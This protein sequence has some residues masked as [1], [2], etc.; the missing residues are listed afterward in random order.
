[1]SEA[2]PIHDE[3]WSLLNAACDDS[4][5]ETQARELA[6]LLDADDTARRA[7][8]E[9]VQLRTD[10]R[11][12]HLAHKACDNGLAQIQATFSEPSPPA[13]LPIAT[14]H[15]TPGNTFQAWSL[16][17]L[18]TAVLFGVAVWIGA[19]V[20]VSHL[21]KGSPASPSHI[22]GTRVDVGRITALADCQWSKQGSGISKTKDLRPK[23]VF[24]GD[25]FLV[26]SGLL[27]ITY[28]TGAT[29][30]LEGPCTYEIDSN[31][32]G[33]LA[34]GKLTAR[35]EKGSG[36]RGPGSGKT[37]P[38]A[39][40]LQPSALFAVRTPTAIVTDLGTEFGVEV[41]KSGATR[42]HV[43]QGSVEVRS[44][45]SRR[46]TTSGE[47]MEILRAGQSARVARGRN[48]KVVITREPGQP[49]HF[50]R[51]INKS[52]NQ[53]IS[54]SHSLIPAPRPLTPRY[55]L[56]DLG[57]LGGRTS[58]AYAISAGGQIVGA[59]EYSK[60]FGHAF[61]YSNGKM[62]D[63]G[64]LDGHQSSSANDINAFGHIIG[65]SGSRSNRRAFLYKNGGMMDLGTLGG[66]A[67]Y[68]LAINDAGKS[69]ASRRT[70]G[71]HGERLSIAATKECMTSAP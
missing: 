3:R 10:I 45:N 17:Y 31:R 65:S 54:K 2:L 4:L 30:I 49:N 6:A 56:T 11:F 18:V 1:M 70:F 29:V 66:P 20:R 48:N 8:I 28:D 15:G 55:H 71:A 62:H 59:A 58:C 24:L 12:L 53:Q 14:M 40:S 37:R 42:S 9:H 38:S 41:E 22:T 43:F 63:L 39:F 46:L 32:G 57:T 16:A 34:V 67:A 33:F 47:P 7:Y 27:E 64:A 36:V 35:V 51:Q 19:Y 69:W 52:P 50:V 44:S 68:A 21:D 60:G 26:S 5:D 25:R 23:T 61:L 13:V